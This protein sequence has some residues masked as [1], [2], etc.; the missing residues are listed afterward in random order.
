M[1]ARR[2]VS[3]VD[4]NLVDTILKTNLWAGIL[5]YL[6]QLIVCRE[7]ARHTACL[8]PRNMTISILTFVNV[9][10]SPQILPE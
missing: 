4:K 8:S 7:F 3:R 5:S 6:V 1:E 9:K 2:M 10:F